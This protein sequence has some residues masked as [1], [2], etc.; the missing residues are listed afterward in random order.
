[1]A[2]GLNPAVVDSDNY[3]ELTCPCGKGGN[4]HQENVMIFHR[5]ED[6][7]TT[8]VI[9]QDGGTVQA[10]EFPSQDTCN[11]STRRGGML[12]EFSCEQCSYSAQ[13]TST[14][15]KT[16]RLAIFQH[17]GNTFMEWLD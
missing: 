11:P 2:F 7:D 10:T 5:G 8:T 13:E 14:P 1:M 3:G 4:I 17:K 9:A 16:F 15:D 12:I 6:G